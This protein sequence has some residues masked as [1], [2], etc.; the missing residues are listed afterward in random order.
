MPS[1]PVL[2]ARY[3]PRE[4]AVSRQILRF[5]DEECRSRHLSRARLTSAQRMDLVRVL[6]GRGLFATRNAAAQV[7]RAVGV[8]RI[9]VYALFK[10]ARS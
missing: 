4:N 10:E 8:S 3:L 7:G 5:G 1:R 2:T 9:I 6:D